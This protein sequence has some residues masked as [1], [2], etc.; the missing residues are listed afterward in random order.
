MNKVEI[1]ENKRAL[2]ILSLDGGGVR[3]ILQARIL[4][5]MEQYLNHKDGSELPLGKRFDLI[6]GT[7][8]GAIMGL[9]LAIGKSASETLQHWAG[10]PDGAGKIQ[11]IFGRPR[12]FPQWLL[13]KTMYDSD[14][15][16]KALENW[17][18]NDDESD[19]KLRDLGP[20]NDLPHVVITSTALAR[21]SLRS[22]K[23]PWTKDFVSRADRKLS[24]VAYASAAAP[25]F[26]APSGSER[27]DSPGGSGQAD[28]PNVD[29]GLCANN[30]AVV[31]IT[32]ALRMGAS[33][34]RIR[35]VSVG[36]G[37]PC[38]MP[39]DPNGIGKKGALRWFLTLWT[40]PSIKPDPAVPLLELVLE[41]Q[42]NMAHEQARFM[43]GGEKGKHRYLR[44]NPQ[45][46]FPMKLDEIEKINL[47]TAYADLDNKTNR[48]LEDIFLN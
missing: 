8:V 42:S 44:I 29:G 20:L 37:I 3:G 9:S 26:F 38:G 24:E 41:A 11:E 4:K 17:F 12:S 13:R 30:P 2:R 6:A 15:L 36:T 21:P 28:A 32:E 19:M 7:S 39:Y 46:K 1:Q 43:L 10:E 23:S 47:L 35:L 31:A 48:A 34:E 27:T 5:N 18:K 22:W 33:L 14:A 25:T 45:L 40:R 16:K